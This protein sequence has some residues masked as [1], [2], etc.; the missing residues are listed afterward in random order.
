MQH[1]LPTEKAAKL[2]TAVGTHLTRCNDRTVWY[3]SWKTL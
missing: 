3:G 1:V 2:K